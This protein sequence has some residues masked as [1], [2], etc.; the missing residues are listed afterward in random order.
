MQPWDMITLLIRDMQKGNHA[1][2]V[3][4]LTKQKGNHAKCV[5]TLTKQTE[6]LPNLIK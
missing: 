6:S 2:C 1:K 5:P 3:P 4:T